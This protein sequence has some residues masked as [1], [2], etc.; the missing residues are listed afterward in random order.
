MRKPILFD[1]GKNLKTKKWSVEEIK[2]HIQFPENKFPPR[3][4][5][6]DED[7]LCAGYLASFDRKVSIE[8]VVRMCKSKNWQFFNSFVGDF[9]ILAY[10][11]RSREIFVLTDMTGKFPCYFTFLKDGFVISTDFVAVRN[12]LSSLTLDMKA[13]FD[14][15][16]WSMYISENTI[17]S[18]IRRLPPAT[19][20]AI[21]LD[22]LS[23]TLTPIV[24]FDSFLKKKG[25]IYGSNVEFT[26]EFLSLL[27]WLTKERLEA[28]HNLPFAAE[29]SSGFDV[30]LICYLLKRLTK[31]PF[32]CYSMVAELMKTDTDVNVMM[33]FAKKHDLN[34]KI[35]RQDHI[36]PFSTKADLERTAHNPIALGGEDVVHF[37]KQL[38]KDG[39]AI[40]FTGDGGDEVYQ[41]HDLDLMGKFPIQ[42]IYF[43]TVRKVKFGADKILTQ[44]GL[45]FLLN[46]DR[47]AKKKYFPQILA[48]SLVRFNRLAFQAY[49]DV[50]MWPV[51]PFADPRLVQLARRMP[52]KNS[53][54][55]DK[56]VLWKHRT[57]IFTPSQFKPKGGA[58]YQAN[59]FLDKKRDFIIKVLSNSVLAEK[60][61]IKASE[62]IKDARKGN[63]D[64][65]R[66]WGAHVY[67]VSILR[68]EYFLQHNNAKIAKKLANPRC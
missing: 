7:F 30:T 39:V 12:K 63:M 2:R 36:F 32:S 55:P 52:R 35:I 47:F 27:S 1:F 59:L 43:N 56:Q 41:S 15:I 9:L 31:N 37:Q 66:V 64:K 68:L 5:A 10:D 46:R 49:W 45:D 33:K 38:A 57:D 48:P 13:V 65:Y 23:Y 61:L 6:R 29:L 21:N 51:Q 34:V 54:V 28:I 58:E 26:N 11:A 25:S 20:L 53:K 18:E 60:G 4:E 42:E 17:I 14:F 50:G 67:L 19:V 40:K 62:I 22:N 44:K 16:D 3:F 24:D 8:E